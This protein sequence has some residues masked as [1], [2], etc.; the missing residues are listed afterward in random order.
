MTGYFRPLLEVDA[1]LLFITLPPS[2]AYTKK[3]DVVECCVAVVR[4]FSCC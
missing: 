3:G 1:V 4:L 2:Y